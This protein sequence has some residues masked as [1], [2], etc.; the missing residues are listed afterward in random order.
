M[1][2]EV[3]RDLI[4]AILGA[5]IDIAEAH[6]VRTI[7]TDRVALAA[8]DKDGHRWRIHIIREPIK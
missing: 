5:H 6:P 2:P 7:Y 8:E 1:T 3:L 4:V